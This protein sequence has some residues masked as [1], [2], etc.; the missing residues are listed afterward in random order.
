MKK[1][2]LV[3]VEGH[4]D[5]VELGRLLNS[6]YFPYDKNKYKLL[7]KAFNYDVSSSSY[8]T[9]KNLIQSISNKFNYLRKNDNDLRLFSFK[10]YYRIVHIADL[11]GTFINS[12]SI[13][14]DKDAECFIY[15]DDC[16]KT[17]RTN[18]AK[19]RNKKKRE[20][21]KELV[22]RDNI[23]GIPYALYFVSC[24]MDHVL[25]NDRNSSR[26]TKQANKERFLVDDEFFENIATELISDVFTKNNYIE[27]WKEI[28]K[29]HNSLSRKTNINL[30]FKDIE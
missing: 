21:L 29:D 13:V 12:D 14:F 18:V 27:S 17:K 16:I 26:E 11:D 6:K 28:Y 8:T 9:S 4:N 25:F 3:L 19:A 24:N 10:D 23:E 22:K 30:V 1:I 2:I 20:L 5:V 7:I 15:E